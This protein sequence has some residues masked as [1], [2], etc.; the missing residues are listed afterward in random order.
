MS[1]LPMV[2]AREKQCAY[3]PSSEEGPTPPDLHSWM[4]RLG[5]EGPSPG[6][7]PY[8]EG[9][10]GQPMWKSVKL[11]SHGTHRPGPALGK[12]FPVPPRPPRRSQAQRADEADVRH[13]PLL[14]L[15]NG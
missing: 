13:L 6:T 4:A 8:R 3:R 5:V 14:P 1:A 11:G 12:R 10:S 9:G 15:R 7:R 2:L